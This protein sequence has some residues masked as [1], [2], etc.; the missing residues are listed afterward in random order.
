M[1]PVRTADVPDLP[2]HSVAVTER[3]RRARCQVHRPKPLIGRSLDGRYYDPATA[4]FLSVDPDVAE[5]DRPYIYASDDPVNESDP[6]GQAPW[7]GLCIRFVNCPSGSSSGVGCWWPLWYSCGSTPPP[8]PCP[9]TSPTTTTT[10]PP[11]TTTT[12]PPPSTLSAVSSIYFTNPAIQQKGKACNINAQSTD[13]DDIPI[14]WMEIS[15][16]QVLVQTFIGPSGFAN[17]LVAVTGPG[18]NIS[19]QGAPPALN[20]APTESGIYRVRTYEGETGSYTL[21][22]GLNFSA[23]ITV[24]R[25]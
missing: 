9:K 6:S 2:A 19:E 18:T 17:G 13:C 22:P 25:S 14:A 11:T 5:T 15:G 4:Q 16:T 8:P 21:I 1:E 23:A 7:S 24:V 3:R 10:S 20:F 12:Q